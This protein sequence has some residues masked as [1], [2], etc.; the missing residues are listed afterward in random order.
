[1]Q[2]LKFSRSSKNGDVA[3]T[4]GPESSVPE[5]GG[6]VSQK[7]RRTGKTIHGKITQNTAMC[8]RN[9]TLV[10]TSRTHWYVLKYNGEVSMFNCD[11]CIHL[12]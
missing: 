1:M 7:L 12:F 11:V 5:D 3:G 10:C 8:R 2:D 6:N 9:A 4:T